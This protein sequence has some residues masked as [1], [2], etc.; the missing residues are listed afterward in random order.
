MLVLGTEKIKGEKMKTFFMG[1]FSGVALMM[2][3]D[4]VKTQTL[5]PC[6]LGGACIACAGALLWLVSRR[7]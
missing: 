1:M 6:V 3:A 4:A 7:G 5:T 2:F